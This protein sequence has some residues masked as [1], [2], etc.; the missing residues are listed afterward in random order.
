MP[1]NWR[2]SR[3]T[4]CVVGTLEYSCS[5]QSTSGCSEC[6][7]A[8]LSMAFPWKTCEQPHT[9]ALNGV[10]S[11]KTWESLR[12]GGVY[13]TKWPTYCK[14]PPSP[15]PP[16]PRSPFPLFNRL[17]FTSCS[18]V[19]SLTCYDSFCVSLIKPALT[20]RLQS[21]KHFQ[22]VSSFINESCCWLRF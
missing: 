19:V 4:Y 13:R 10:S 12:R 5:T 20:S 9:S 21:F 16:S 1:S 22:D 11:P 18:V 2:Q 6:T 17:I 8:L 7:L 14:K 3:L 15:Q